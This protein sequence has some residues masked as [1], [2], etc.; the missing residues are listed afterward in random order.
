M[1]STL[2]DEDMVVIIDGKE[3]DLRTLVVE[4]L[5]KNGEMSFKEL[6][7][8]CEEAI[9]KNS[10]VEIE[11]NLNSMRFAIDKLIESKTIKQTNEGKPEEMLLIL[12]NDTAY[13]FRN[14]RR[15]R[16]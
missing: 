4:A 10:G 5:S 2:L 7:K 14:V 3:Y 12:R 1:Y 13:G 9:R 8:Y 11:I 15:F 6:K 16:N